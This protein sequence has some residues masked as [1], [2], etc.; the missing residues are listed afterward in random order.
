MPQYIADNTDDEDSHQKF[1]NAFLASVG[2]EPV[3]DNGLVFPDLNAPP[4]GG[5]A[6]QT[7]L[8]MP[9]PCDFISEN[10]PDCSIIR[11]TRNRVAGARATAAFLRGGP[12]GRMS[13]QRPARMPVRLCLT[14]ERSQKRYQCRGVLLGKFLVESWHLSFDAVKDSRF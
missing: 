10:L 11:P 14:L 13:K 6:F 5:E 4:F 1:L 3:N 2:A 12:S 8:I 7:N 9:E